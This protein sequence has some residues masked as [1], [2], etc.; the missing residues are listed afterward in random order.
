MTE[1]N[2]PISVPP[3]EG[4]VSG[5]GDDLRSALEDAGSKLEIDGSLLE[6]KLDLAHFKNAKSG[7]NVGVDTV[8]IWAWPK[9]KAVV[10]VSERAKAWM[11]ELLERMEFGGN[12]AVRVDGKTVL[13]RV[14]TPKGGHFVGK[15]GVTLNAVRTLMDASLG[16]E[17]PDFEFKVDVAD[18]RRERDDRG[19]GRDRDDRGRGRDR[20]DRGRGRGRDDRGRGRDRDDR[21]RGRDRDDRPRGRGRDRDDRPRGRDRDDRPRGR[22]RD[23]RRERDGD[24]EGN[25]ARNRDIERLAHRLAK[26]VLSSGKAE[27]IR[28]E[29]N[30]YARRI[31]H[32]VVAEYEGLE[33]E[34][35]G[36][37]GHKQVRILP[38][39]GEQAEA[40]SE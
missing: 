28:K 32:M 3:V 20:D 33:T 23:D 30:S 38:A 18:Q 40:A 7:I 13:L 22:D 16:A 10:E 19:R 8:K 9:D 25:K 15:Q 35:V 17:H 31:V 11:T 36:D 14:D 1:E 37:G 26:R 21:G 5:E 39:G 12:V 27:L 24:D 2:T 4:A 6:Y 34:S 29:M